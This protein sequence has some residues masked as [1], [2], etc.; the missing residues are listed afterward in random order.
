MFSLSAPAAVDRLVI[1]GGDRIVLRRG[2][3]AADDCACAVDWVPTPG[4]GTERRVA[5]ATPYGR[6]HVVDVATGESRT[7]HGDHEDWIRQLRVSSDGRQ[8]ASTSQNGTGR[9]FDLHHGRLVAR[10][11]LADHVVA[12]LDITPDGDAVAVEPHGELYRLDLE[13][14]ATT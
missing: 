1:A 14:H 8:V 6:V 9:V 10:R 7:L 3:D 13:Q 12:S 11:Q 4:G 2:V 5:V